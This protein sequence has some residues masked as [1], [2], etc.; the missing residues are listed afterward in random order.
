M[1]CSFWLIDSRV[2]NSHRGLYE[3]RTS[4][5][6]HETTPY[7]LNYQL[8]AI[9]SSMKEVPLGDP[10]EILS[11]ETKETEDLSKFDVMDDE[12]FADKNATVIAKVT[13]N[14]TEPISYVM[15]ISSMA[16]VGRYRILLGSILLVAIYVLLLLEVINRAVVAFIGAFLTL[17]LISFISGAPSLST[18]VNWMDESTLCLLF[19]MM[20]MIQM[21]STTGLFEYMAVTMLIWSHGNIKV[22]NICLCLLTALCSAFLDNVTT[23][24]LIAPV[25]I[26]VSRMMN[27]N[28]IPFLLPEVIFSNLAG[29]ATQIGDPPNII[30]GNMLKEHI[31]FVDFI[32]H[33]TPCVIICLIFVYPFVLWYY[34]KDLN[35]PN[36]EVDL[37]LR[38][39]YQIKNKP[40]LLKCGTVLITVIIL[41]FLHSFHHVDTAF[42]AVAGAFACFFLGTSED[43]HTTFELLEWETLVF[44]AGL[45]IMIEGINELGVIRAIGEAVSSLIIKTPVKWQSFLAHMMILWV[46]GLASSVLDNIAFTATMIPVIQ[47]LGSHEEL[48]LDVVTLA[49][50][51]A[52]GACFGGNGTLVGAGAN[53]VTAGIC[54]TNGHPVTFGMF[55]KFG[56]SCMIISM[57]VSTVYITIRYV[58][59]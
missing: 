14:S 32:I 6:R 44:F 5:E 11:S 37:S 50:A 55:F 31:G 51:L 20:I 52:L 21:L 36:F 1:D 24:L 3:I 30:I 12:V 47:V 8:Y 10:V 43:L 33:L 39:K 26:E 18:V 41:F 42:L 23:M 59:F 4:I 13:T 27:V 7:T 57:V 34:W 56:F 35:K 22:L 28:P 38:E 29:T 40:L 15:Y 45:F 54:A 25:T 19:G 2:D 49:W 46:S 58:Q 16:P 53:L 48:N 9:D 17:L